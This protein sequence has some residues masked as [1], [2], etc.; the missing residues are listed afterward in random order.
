MGEAIWPIEI[1]QFNKEKLEA[2][3]GQNPGN[4]FI[5]NANNEAITKY[6]K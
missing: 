5:L 6:T 2:A 3:S 1:A 4:P